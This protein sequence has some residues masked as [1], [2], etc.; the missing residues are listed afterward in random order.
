M[1]FVATDRSINDVKFDD[2]YNKE[3]EKYETARKLIFFKPEDAAYIYGGE[4]TDEIDLLE[5]KIIK[6]K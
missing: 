1:L 5:D 4:W 6:E 3:K 2:E